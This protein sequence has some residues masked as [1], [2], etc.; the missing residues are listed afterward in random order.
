MSRFYVSKCFQRLHLLNGADNP[1]N[2]TELQPIG[3]RP[4]KL[5]VIDFKV[6]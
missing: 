3:Y 4:E 2:S 5:R 6:Y 1:C